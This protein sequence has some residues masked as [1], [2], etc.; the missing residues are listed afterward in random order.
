MESPKTLYLC[1]EGGSQGSV[2]APH[3]RSIRSPSSHGQNRSSQRQNSLSG[4][5]RR[6]LAPKLVAQIRAEGFGRS[7]VQKQIRKKTQMVF[8]RYGEIVEGIIIRPLTYAFDVLSEGRVQCIDKISI[9]YMYKRNQASLIIMH[10]DFDEA[11]KR[12]KLDAIVPRSQRFQVE[13]RILKRCRRENISVTSTLRGGEIITGFV[14]WFSQYEIKVNV[15]NSS[16]VV[17]FRHGLHN[18]RVNA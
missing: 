4:R 5:S 15:T 6:P 14:D 8:A 10:I 16:G 9:K 17:I 18:Y 11:V 13:D 12:R 7:Y 1:A 2:A 3:K